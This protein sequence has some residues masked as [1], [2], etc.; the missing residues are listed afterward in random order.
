[1]SGHISQRSANELGLSPISFDGLQTNF[2]GRCSL[3][4]YTPIS[5]DP[6]AEIIRAC[7]KAAYTDPLALFHYNG[8]PRR[9]RRVA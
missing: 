8:R 4:T 7:K 1:M 9:T 5:S 6:T 3:R 2:E